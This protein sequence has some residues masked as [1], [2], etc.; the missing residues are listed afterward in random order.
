MMTLFQ[1]QE[2]VPR[3]IECGV[4]AVKLYEKIG[5][6]SSQATIATVSCA[7]TGQ[8]CLMR[9]DFSVAFGALRTS[10]LG[11][12]QIRECAKV[13]AASPRNTNCEIRS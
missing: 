11:R 2:N 6:A 1:S 12:P 7:N 13:L 5:G 4:E 10:K 8:T 9:V 3:S